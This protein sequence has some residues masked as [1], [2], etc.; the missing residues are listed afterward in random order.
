MN[1]GNDKELND[2]LDFSAVSKVIM[3][4]QNKVKLIFNVLFTFEVSLVCIA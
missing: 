3:S 1:V 4:V 2:L